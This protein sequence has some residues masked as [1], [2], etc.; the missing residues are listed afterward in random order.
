M[1]TEKDVMSRV[2]IVLGA[3]LLLA[4]CVEGRFEPFGGLGDPVCMP[5]GSV[6]FYQE[7]AADGTLGQPRA[8]KE[9]CAWN[10]PA[11]P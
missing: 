3:A 1:N 5:D 6:A 11:K 9:Y 10:K 4:G 8:K 7:A 2:G